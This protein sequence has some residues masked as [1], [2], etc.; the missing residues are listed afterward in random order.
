MLRNATSARLSTCANATPSA[1]PI[2]AS[3]RLSTRSWRTNRQRE[4]PMAS[5][6]ATSRSRTLA[7]ANSRLA[8]FAQAIRST[9]PVVASSSHSGLSYSWRRSETPVPPRLP[10]VCWRGSAWRCRAE[11]RGAA[12]P[13]SC[14]ATRLGDARWPA[15]PSNR[16]LSVPSWTATRRG[17]RNAAFAVLGQETVGT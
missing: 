7:R 1:E 14:R 8:R 10:R 15:P 2:S 4:A 13:A 16:A 6:T 11:N 12:S 17:D 9:R 5:R 3:N